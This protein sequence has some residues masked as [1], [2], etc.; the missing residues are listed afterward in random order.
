MSGKDFSR[1][2]ICSTRKS[3]VALTRASCLD[4]G[5]TCSQYPL[6]IICSG[7]DREKPFFQMGHKIRDNPNSGTSGDGIHLGNH[8]CASKLRGETGCYLFHKLQ[9]P[10]EQQIINVT[11]YFMFF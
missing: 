9:I 6:S 2:A 5:L 3:I 4:S 8:G 11:D 1:I 10:V 7:Q